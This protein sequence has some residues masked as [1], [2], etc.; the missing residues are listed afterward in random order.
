M[1]INYV[2][3]I[4]V[5]FRYSLFSEKIRKSV[6]PETLCAVFC[7]GR[8]CKYDSAEVWKTEDLAVPGIYSHW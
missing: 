4:D 3:L 5:K 1:F 8:K 6:P 2:D 7:G